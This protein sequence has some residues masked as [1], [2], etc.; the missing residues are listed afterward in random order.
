MIQLNEVQIL[1]AVEKV[2]NST[3]ALKN[4]AF[5]TLVDYYRKDI[6]RV[7]SSILKYIDH[8]DKQDAYQFALSAFAELISAKN[9]EYDTVS[10]FESYIRGTL[11][12]RINKASIRESLG[13][14]PLIKNLTNIEINL[15][16]AISHFHVQEHR[17]PVFEEGEDLKILA[18]ILDK[19]VKTVKKWILAFGSTRIKSLYDQ[20]SQ[21][22]GEDELLLIDSLKSSI[23]LPDEVFHKEL[24]SKTVREQVK[25]LLTSEQRLVFDLYYH[26]DDPDAV[27][28]TREQVA[29]KA[30]L[31]FRRTKHLLDTSK[32]Q[33]ANDELLQSLIG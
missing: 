12:K 7:F 3:G 15:G 33:I 25:T 5:E 4:K 16:R 22:E 2:R 19:P 18:D 26:F 31:S 27:D 32:E 20:V 28:L 10:R 17:E 9:L 13:Y 6:N 14:N 30:N 8:G 1:E 21:N 23:P 29:E 24:L 11:P